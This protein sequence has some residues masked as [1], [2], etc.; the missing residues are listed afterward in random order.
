M[1]ASPSHDFGANYEMF[2]N[3]GELRGKVVL[4]R[5]WH[6]LQ[7]CD[8]SRPLEN[9]RQAYLDAAR[10]GVAYAECDVWATKDG[11]VVLSHDFNFKW[12]APCDQ[13]ESAVLPISDLTWENLFDLELLDGSKPVKLETVLED[14]R[15]S[16]TR[17]VIE[18]KTPSLAASLGA[19]MVERR[20][21][22]SSVAWVMSFS[23]SALE[24]FCQGGGQ[25]AGVS[26]MWL[27]D[28][29]DYLDKHEGETTFDYSNEDLSQLLLRHELVERIQGLQCGLYIQ[30]RA[31]LRLEVFSQ[32]RK[33]LM[34]T[35]Q[36]KPDS[37]VPSPLLGLWTDIDLDAEFDKADTLMKWG[38]Y[39][40]A[41]NTDLPSHFWMESTSNGEEECCTSSQS[42]LIT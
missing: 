14:L 18:I 34:D 29:A 9:T 2:A 36:G 15:E 1:I 17:L 26:T 42:P 38:L 11:V 3:S 35:L 28:N 13:N 30:Y 5:G 39:A 41:V 21:L 12:G 8:T 33:D 22:L 19:F 25:Q 37:K 4:H 6:R 7:K 10:L 32:I 24:Q 31:S 27:L 20:D 23:F 40:D 16:S